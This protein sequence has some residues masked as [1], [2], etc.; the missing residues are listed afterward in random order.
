ML[1]CPSS[2][3]CS[4]S[5]AKQRSLTIYAFQITSTCVCVCVCV[6]A[7]GVRV[8][9]RVRAWCVCVCVCVCDRYRLV[10]AGE[11]TEVGFFEN[12]PFKRKGM[13]K[14]HGKFVNCARYSP[15]G[16]VFV[17]ADAGGKAFIY[18]GKEGTLKGEL[19]G[20]EASAHKVRHF[21]STLSLQ[22]MRA[23]ALVCHRP[24]DHPSHP[25]PLHSSHQSC[26]ST[27]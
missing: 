12:V 20:G 27:T 18:D 16:E 1:S 13:L 17:T 11:D 3:L 22:P 15:D 24:V 5:S 9:A 2:T 4:P 6:R 21:V 8:C 23:L 10:T 19:T 25:S 14:E 7:R 26:T